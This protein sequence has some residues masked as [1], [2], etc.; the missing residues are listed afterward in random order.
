MDKFRIDDQFENN[1]KK[2]KQLTNA[3][4]KHLKMSW[5]KSID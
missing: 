1:S 5:M 3:E 4:Q 2:D